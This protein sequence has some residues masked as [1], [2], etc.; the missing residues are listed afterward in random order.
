MTAQQAAENVMFLCQASY[1]RMLR[2]PHQVLVKEAQ[3]IAW[4]YLSEFSQLPINVSSEERESLME[5]CFDPDAEAAVTN[6][7][8]RDTY[9]AIYNLVLPIYREWLTTNEWREVG[10]FHHIPPPTFSIVLDSPELVKI[11]SRYL[12]GLLKTCTSDTLNDM[13]QLWHFCLIAND[14]RN[15]N[16]THEAELLDGKEGGAKEGMSKEEY[17]K[18]LYR[19]YKRVVPLPHDR[20]MPYAVYVVS[21]LDKSIEMFEGS[22]V[23]VRWIG[24]KQYIGVDFQSRMVHQTLTPDGYAV[25]PS[26]AAAISS[27]M[28][29]SLSVSLQDTD[30]FRGCQFVMELLNFEGLAH[31]AS[32]PSSSAGASS[33]KGS[34]LLKQAPV[35]LGVG[36]GGAGESSAVVCTKKEVLEEAKRI[37]QTYLE[38]GKKSGLY[39][40]PALVEEVRAALKA[41]GKAKS[42]RSDVFHR[43]GA[44]VY[45]RVDHLIGREWRASLIWTNKSYDNNCRRAKEILAM[46]DRKQLP[47]GT[48]FK[49]VPAIDD[50][51][52]NDALKADF[53]AFIPAELRGYLAQYHAQMLKVIQLPYDQRAEEAESAVMLMAAGATRMKD[54][55]PFYKAVSKGIAGRQKISNGPFTLFFYVLVNTLAKLYYRDWVAARVDTWSTVPWSPVAS[56][57]FS[58][59]DTAPST[60]DYTSK[61]GAEGKHGWA[62]LF[63]RRAAKK[64]APPKSPV[65]PTAKTMLVVPPAEG[66][67]GAASPLFGCGNG[68]GSG[69]NNGLGGGGSSSGLGGSGFSRTFT[70][71]PGSP[72]PTARHSHSHAALPTASSSGPGGANSEDSL[73]SS[74]MGRSMPSM[75]SLQTLLMPPVPSLRDT[76]SSSYLRHLFQEN[77]LE[78]RLPDDMMELWQRLCAFYNTYEPLAAGDLEA[79]QDALRTD[80]AAILDRYESFMKNGYFLRSHIA[81]KGLMTASFFRDEECNQF[82]QYYSAYEAFLRQRGWTSSD[83]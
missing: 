19:K 17:A 83:E 2:A 10:H 34:G 47:A 75:P 15:G 60:S 1:F 40:D 78:S 6:T 30:G 56:V 13:E 18:R 70:S 80:A 57:V 31:G 24:Q 48:D 33:A 61:L 50:V 5:V 41:A 23:F 27:S 42:V 4:T 77:F 14:F 66:M 32:S 26:F 72:E 69:G 74:N 43:V 9:T 59:M 29:A 38:D 53:E 3:H 37:Y 44:Y 51:L 54:L 46:F 76:L 21:A 28:G 25:P 63:G 58:H 35:L 8:F 39:C 52:A 71:L 64:H 16:M 79:S 22:P 67:G 62:A 68:S 45:N 49:L 7:V 73:S 82:R 81:K 36:V 65:Y 20:T 55:E 12:R 11:F